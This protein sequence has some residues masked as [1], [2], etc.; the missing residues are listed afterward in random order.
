MHM[1]FSS[2]AWFLFWEALS[3]WELFSINRIANTGTHSSFFKVLANGVQSCMQAWKGH[4]TVAKSNLAIWA[5]HHITCHSPPK[6]LIKI[7]ITLTHQN[8]NWMLQW[9]VLHRWF[10]ITVITS[11]LR[12]IK[13]Q[14]A[15]CEVE[16]SHKCWMFQFLCPPATGTKSVAPRLE[17]IWQKIGW[18]CKEGRWG[19]RFGKLY[20]A[21]AHQGSSQRNKIWRFVSE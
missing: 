2:L 8:K 13:H 3:F 15:T 5:K 18:G 14:E 21:G 11:P 12:P 4:S 10:V 9:G 16:V 7:L 6:M 1:L 20:I 17:S 19:W